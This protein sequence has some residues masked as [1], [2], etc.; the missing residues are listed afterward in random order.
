MLNNDICHCWC[1]R[2]NR[3]WCFLATMR[4]F[5]AIIFLPCGLHS[6]ICPVD[7]MYSSTGG[8]LGCSER[9]F[10][11]DTSNR[12]TR[13]H[14]ATFF[15]VC[16]VVCMWLEELDNTIGEFHDSW[17]GPKNKMKAAVWSVLTR[18]HVEKS[19][20]EKLFEPPP[21]PSE[22]RPSSSAA[23]TSSSTFQELVNEPATIPVQDANFPTQEL[24]EKTPMAIPSA[25]ESADVEEE[26]KK[27]NWKIRGGWSRWSVWQCW[28][29]LIGLTKSQ[30]RRTM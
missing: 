21:M 7:K 17:M 6:V 5:L 29:R 18:R 16:H 4:S 1:N 14:A 11:L 12:S 30:I 2:T 13:L 24:V 23:H 8:F 3:C 15:W 27:Y 22:E 25:D 10:L 28:K 19:L 9:G 26:Q 20:R